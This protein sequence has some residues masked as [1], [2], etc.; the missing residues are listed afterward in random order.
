MSYIHHATILTPY[1]QVN[2]GVVLIEDSR[3]AAVGS[4]DDVARSL[5][6]QMIDATGLSLERW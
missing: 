5:S 4:V 1:N 2:D 6:S 3:I